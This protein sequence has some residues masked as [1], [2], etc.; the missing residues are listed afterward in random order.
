[1]IHT[2]QV[3][4]Q[5]DHAAIARDFVI[6][7]ACRD[8]GDFKRSKIP[9]IALQQCR[10]LSVVYDWGSSCYILYHRSDAEKASL[11]QTLES[12]EADVCVREI[13]SQE[14]EK[15][16]NC[17]LA[18]LLFNAIPSLSSGSTMYHNITGKLYY[19]DSKWI[20]RR[21][22]EL[23]GFWTLQISISWDLCI[24]L[25]VRTFSKVH[26]QRDVLG[27]PQH[28]FDGASFSLRRV[29]KEDPDAAANHFVIA[30]MF[31][32]R[33]NTVPFLEFGSLSEYYS[34]K[35]GVLHRF[36]KDVQNILSPYITLETVSLDETTH[37]GNKRL[38]SK[39][40]NIRQCLKEI[41]VYVEDTVQ[42]EQSTALESML[43]Q[44]LKQYS[45]ISLTKGSPTKGSVLIR[46]IHNKEYY[47]NSTE[48]DNY[49]DAP[50]DCIVQHITV[51]DFQLNGTNQRN[52]KEKED[53]NLRKVLQELAIKID[54]AKEQ[55]SFYDWKS[56][57]FPPALTFV[58]ASKNG[59]GLV[60]YRRLRVSTEGKLCFDTWEQSFFYANDEQEKIAAAFETRNGKFDSKV[61]GLIYEEADNIQIIRDTDRYT[62]PNMEVLEQKLSATRDDEMIP[63]FSVIKVLQENLSSFTGKKRIQCAEILDTLSHHSHQ[64]SRK[65]LRT[66]LN[67]K[68]TLGREL[69][70]LIYDE[71]GTLIASRIKERTNRE[72]ILGGTLDIRHFHV[73][74]AQYYYSGYF[75]QSLKWSLPHAC[76]IRKITSTGAMLNFEKYLPL[77]EVDFVRTNAWTVIPFPFKYLRE[78]TALQR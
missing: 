55:M 35:V 47:T 73:G 39:M 70:Q 2:N 20:Y 56:L 18:Q 46:I 27:K 11:K 66:I 72:S 59:D 14:L 63:L 4:L 30:A 49:A 78:W 77:L 12:Y 74:S 43:W 75:G 31:P 23:V 19:M 5:Y 65:E 17:R 61:K 3:N 36:L 48:R 22:E 41:P 9:D 57:G 71:T 21:K 28:L 1:M 69:N 67:L 42:N 6:F 34:C 53:P 29:L 52:A 16:C 58:T 7:E 60:H 64:V 50:K 51:E 33:K 26:N 13:T 76:R 62:L 37:I 40:M 44:E 38:D 10:A 8:N 25:E 15:K 45:D 24:K 68:S 32:N 54:I